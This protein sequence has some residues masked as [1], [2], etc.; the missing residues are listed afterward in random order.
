MTALSICSFNKLEFAVYAAVANFNDG[1]QASIV[2]LNNMNIHPGYHTIPI[3]CEL[4]KRRKY[5]AAY[6]AKDP[7]KKT[8]TIIRVECNNQG[9]KQNQREGSIYKAGAFKSFCTPNVY[10]FVRKFM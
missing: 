3:F 5:L 10:N 8:R 1:R 7:T 6:K 4:N 9:V 2:M